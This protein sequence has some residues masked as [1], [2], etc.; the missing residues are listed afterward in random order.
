MTAAEEWLTE[1]ATVHRL[2]VRYGETDQM[3]VVYHAHYIVW[4][5]EARDALLRAGGVDVSS[6]ERRGFRFPVI[7]VACHYYH[8]AR[9]GEEVLITAT[10]GVTTVARLRFRFEVASARNNRLL[11]DGE[12]TSVITDASGRLL[13][14]IPQELAPFFTRYAHARREG[15]VKKVS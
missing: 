8:P 13:I 2:R 12:T 7:D 11:A 1:L 4:F 3:G 5:N 6:I 10:P 15:G 9:F 14:R